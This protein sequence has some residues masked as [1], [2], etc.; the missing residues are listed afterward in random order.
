MIHHT[1][2][3]VTGYSEAGPGDNIHCHK[4]ASYHEE[5]QIDALKALGISYK[6][7]EESG[8]IIP[9]I[10]YKVTY[11]KKVA[12]DEPLSVVVKI[13]NPPTIKIIFDFLVYD[14]REQ[15]V[16]K[17]T[18]VNVIINRHTNRPCYL[19]NLWREVIEEHFK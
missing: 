18:M 8:I 16:N 13:S 15:L 12:V 7:M 2:R 9:V 10:S 5:A 19:P 17:A 4:F 3:L 1:Y 11:L 6:V 14:S